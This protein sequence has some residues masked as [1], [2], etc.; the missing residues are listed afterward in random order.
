MIYFLYDILIFLAALIYL[1]FYALRGRVHCEILTRL[2]FFKKDF[3]LSIKGKD[4]VWVHAVSVGEARAA[5]S[6]FA[7]IR[8]RWPQKRL[9]VSTVTPTGQAIIKKILKDDELSFY[10]PLD[11]SF[12]VKK[13][14]AHIAPGLLIIMET[15]LWPN[16]IRLSKK[17]GAAVVV[18]NGR[19]SD[20]SLRGYQ[21][22]K[23][24]LGPVLKSVDLFCM[25][26]EES[27]QRI[28]DLGV[29]KNRV[30]MTGNIK[31]DISSQ[32]KESPLLERFK[33][34][35]SG[36]LLFVAGS[37][38]EG[39]EEA[40]VAIYQSLRK[41]FSRLRLLIAPRHLDRMDKIRR[42][43]RQEGLESLFF[44]R[45]SSSFS[46]GQVVLLDTIGDLNSLYGFCDVAFVGGSLV[47]KGGHNL[48]EPALF[49]KPIF[50]GRHMENFKEI[51]DIFV[52][53][54]AAIEI[55]SA[56]E[57]EYEL[58]RLLGDPQERKA[59]GERARNLLESNRGAAQRTFSEILK[60][61]KT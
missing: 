23:P 45:L 25:Q 21:R 43:V 37:T 29:A 42:L 53:Q 9:V 26:T 58:R 56:Q 36:S 5:E 54:R 19:I 13:F 24:F 50:F 51:R 60:I 33:N 8:D 44:S 57:L 46:S 11:I 30:R 16:L 41:D 22:L 31:F 61:V 4:V 10:A 6:L 39:E 15:E 12:V 28:I 49:G 7:L 17:N 59:L 20:R 27:A 52:R 35:I 55:N 3:F 18:V 47:E 48:I 34:I 2:G 14:L 32:L 40:I 1:P 38:H